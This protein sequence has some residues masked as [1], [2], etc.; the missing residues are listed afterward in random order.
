MKIQG[1]L[2]KILTENEEQENVKV[3]MYLC[4]CPQGAKQTHMLLGL[5]KTKH[6]PHNGPHLTLRS[7]FPTNVARAKGDTS[8][9]FSILSPIFSLEGWQGK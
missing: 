5:F 8:Y 2:R 1:E 9:T 3:C 7:N 4:V 6:Y